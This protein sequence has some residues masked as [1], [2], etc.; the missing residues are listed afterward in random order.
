MAIDRVETFV[1]V[2]QMSR[3]RGPSIANYT[4]RESVLVK[5]S[6]SSGAV[7]WGETYASAG[8]VQILRD[9]GEMLIGRDPLRS[10]EIH[11][12]VWNASVNPEATSVIAIA[13]DDLRGKLLNMP[14]YGLYGGPL[15]PA[16]APTRR[17]PATSTG[18]T[19][20]TR[21]RMTSRS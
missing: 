11:T 10:G 6:D 12:F 18:W 19:R 20:R 17:A 9:L 7:G 1:L 3:G 14:A 16:S 15:A 21:G 13:V 5:I 4:T 2:H 8:L